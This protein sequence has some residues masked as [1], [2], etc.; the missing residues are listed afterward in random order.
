MDQWVGGWNWLALISWDLLKA[1]QRILSYLNIFNPR[2]HSSTGFSSSPLS[3]KFPGKALSCLLGFTWCTGL[4]PLL[5]RDRTCRYT[6]RKVLATL[7]NLPGH[8]RGLD[9]IPFWIVTLPCPAPLIALCW[10]FDCK[11]LRASICFSAKHPHMDD[12]IQINNKKNYILS[13]TCWKERKKI[14]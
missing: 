9:P 11:V 3:T 12:A 4:L 8:G 2:S 10:L 13:M 1:I 6:F 7:G 14:S 5:Q